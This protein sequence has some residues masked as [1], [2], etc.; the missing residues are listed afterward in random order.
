M[1]YLLDISFL[2]F[3]SLVIICIFAK[4]KWLKILIIFITMIYY[5]IG[6][7]IIGFVISKTIMTTNT[8]IKDC[9]NTSGIILLGAGNIK[10]NN[11]YEPSISAYDRIL[12]TAQVYNA[13]HQPIII[14]GGL[15]EDYNESEAITYAKELYLLGIPKKNITIEDKSKNTYQNAKF[16][17]E[18]IGSSNNS[19]CL[20]TDSDHM[21]RSLMLYNKFDINIIPLASSQPTT[22]ISLLPNTYNFYI[23]QRLIHEVLGYVKD[24]YFH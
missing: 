2:L 16:T 11:I 5:L 12:K 9:D 7:G 10:I 6:T 18:I 8:N 20:I 15:T 13:Y 23:T 22:K 24:I 17:K 1:S 4:P 19:Y 21:K 3:C 14:S